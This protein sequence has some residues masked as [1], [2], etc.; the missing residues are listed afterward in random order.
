MSRDMLNNSGEKEREVWLSVLHGTGG[1]WFIEEQT[2]CAR[3]ITYESSFWKAA[4]L[5]E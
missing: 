4:T 5:A 3:N 2:K 1:A